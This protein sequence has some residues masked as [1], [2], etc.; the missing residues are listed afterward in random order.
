MKKN[1]F[2]FLALTLIFPLALQA[3]EGFNVTEQIQWDGGFVGAGLD[4]ITVKQALQLRDDAYVILRG[5]IVRQLSHD[6][7][8]FQDSSGEI[9]VD[10]DQNKWKG[11]KVTP[12]DTLEIRGEIDKDWN[13]I[14]I[15]V[16]SV[17]KVS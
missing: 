15:D 17:Q 4:A 6:N 11:L 9:N 12:N 8:L 1:I 3:Q 5:K 16:D 2:I 10:I 14:E 13:S 7:Y